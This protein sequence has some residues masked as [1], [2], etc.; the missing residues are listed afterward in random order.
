MLNPNDNMDDLIRKAAEDYPLKTEGEDW[1]KVRGAMQ[2]TAEV[3]QPGRR[4]E[5]WWLLLLLLPLMVAVY[6]MNNNNNA[7]KPVI[8]SNTKVNEKAIEKQNNNRSSDNNDGSLDKD[9]K[10]TEQIGASRTPG[11]QMNEA[12]VEAKQNTSQQNK[13]SNR[14]T[15][16]TISNGSGN[17]GNNNNSRKKTS[18]RTGN[19]NVSNGK[20][21][22]RDL[23]TGNSNKNPTN[24]NNTQAAN[25][26]M[27]TTE[28]INKNKSEKGNASA[29]ADSSNKNMVALTQQKDSSASTKK[30]NTKHTTPIKTKGLYIGVG[31][32]LDV[33]TIKLQKVN[34]IGYTTNLIVGYRINNNWSL[35]SGLMWDSK[36]YYSTGEYYNPKEPIPADYN[37]H[38]LNGICNMFEI[39]LNV[40]YDFRSRQLS[41]FFVTAG[42]SSYLMKKESYVGFFTQ[43]SN[44]TRPGYD[45]SSVYKNS[46]NNIFSVGNISGGY[47]F[48]FKNNSNL[49]IEPYLKVPF[50]GLGYG[51]MPFL[52]TGISAA[53]TIPLH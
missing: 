42:F 39:P 36:K 19:T 22:D 4:K 18:E 32:G 8:Y 27:A 1:D 29:P 11:Q 37:L 16:E 21:S 48:I 49:R 6:Y 45:Y 52:S 43:V 2:S 46:T 53:Y 33:T 9:N 12:E 17:S 40:K 14:K 44:P 50:T 25:G 51:R 31:A 35:E 28:Q 47:Q 5:Y 7:Q 13:Q 30:M 15:T 34:N 26:G 3:V 23:T 38:Y 20:V 10:T 41:G 24:N